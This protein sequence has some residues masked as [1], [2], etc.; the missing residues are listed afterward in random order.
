MDLM[1]G[2][3][4]YITIITIKVIKFYTRKSI[5]RFSNYLEVILEILQPHTLLFSF[6]SKIC[7]LHGY[8]SYVCSI[9]S[10][11]F[12]TPRIQDMYCTSLLV[13]PDPNIVSYP[14]EA[15]SKCLS[16]KRMIHISCECERAS[17]SISLSEDRIWNNSG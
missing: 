14:E 17:V 15:C 7:W 4:L 3:Y 16:M 12:Q 13:A 8:L 5:L 1:S 2:E 11:G 9:L 6:A 10:H